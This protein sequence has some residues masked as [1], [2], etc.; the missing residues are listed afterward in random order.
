MKKTFYQLP[1]E[2]RERMTRSQINALIWLINVVACTACLEEDF[3]TR[4]DC[5]PYGR[6]RVRMTL[7]QLRA[8]IEDLKG[9]ITADQMRRIQNS[10]RDYMMRLVPKQMPKGDVLALDRKHAKLLVDAAQ[11]S[12]CLGCVLDAKECRSCEMYKILVAYLPLDDYSGENCPY[13]MKIHVWEE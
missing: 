2:D 12:R 13:G 1:E 8:I 10:C 5:I 11:E 6:R 9:T 4:L 7:G 3:G